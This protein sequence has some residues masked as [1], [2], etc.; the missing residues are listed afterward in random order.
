MKQTTRWLTAI[1]AASLL[2]LPLAGC[3]TKDPASSSSSTP[4]S[5]SSFNTDEKIKAETGKVSI[6][7]PGYDGKE[8]SGVNNAAYN[9]AVKAF[10]QKYG[11]TVEIVQAVGEQLWNEKVAAQIAAKEPVDVFAIT[12]D[13]YL[14]MYQK[15][16]LL[17]VNDYVDLGRAKLNLSAMD[18]FVKFDGK[19]YAAGVS[20]T[21]YVLYYNKDILSA[22]G[23]DEDEPMNRYKAGSWTWDSFVEI[24]RTCQ[25]AE[26]VVQCPGRY[27]K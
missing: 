26:A 23:Y 21:P 6:L 18:K 8:E 10:E 16:Y 17:P 2:A 9:A 22:N 12:V 11:K 24:A 19:Y 15:N 1:M 25:D 27:E 4:S 3:G 7:I 20:V 5:G 13:Q 14:G